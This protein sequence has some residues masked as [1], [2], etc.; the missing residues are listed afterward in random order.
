[1]EGLSELGI[2]L[3]SLLAQLVNFGILMVLLYLVAYKPILKMMDKRSEKVKE[4]LAQ[5]EEVKQQAEQ[6]EQEL[7]ERLEQAGKQGQD[8]IDR[9]ARTGEEIKQRAEIEAKEEADVLITRA[10]SEIKRERNE[11]VEQLRQEYANLTI[12]AAEKIIDRS[13]DKKAHKDLIEKVM[14]ENAGFSES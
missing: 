9:A 4:N 7:K 5:S 12:M 6:A 1:M 8:I 11:V 3:P 13:L 2:N 10:R 14:E